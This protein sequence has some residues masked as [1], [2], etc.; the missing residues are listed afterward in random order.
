MIAKEVPA[1]Q[2]FLWVALALV[3]P[4]SP[5][6]A[7]ET[8]TGMASFYSDVPDRSQKLTAAHR[9]LPF[10]TMV[11]VTRMDTGAQVVVR[12]NDRGPFIK[13]RIIDV[14]HPAAAQL[15]MIGKGVARVKIQVIPA[16]VAVTKTAT[17]QRQF[18]CAA[19]EV[20]LLLE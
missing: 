11:S 14:S 2:R 3:L 20:P 13:G 7:E 19:C 12:I 17:Q 4:T 5:L 18:V 10:G 15:G 6:A 16:P 8:S 9:S 1:M